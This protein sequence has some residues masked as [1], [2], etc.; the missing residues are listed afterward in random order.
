LHV[1]KIQ[2]RA[3]LI[4]QKTGTPVQFEITQKKRSDLQ[5]WIS[6]KSIRS[7]DYLFGSRVKDDFPLTTRQYAIIVKK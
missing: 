3:M 6:L 7:S 1:K 5:N 2:S 4:Q